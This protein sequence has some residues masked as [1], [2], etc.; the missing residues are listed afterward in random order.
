MKKNIR[1]GEQSL[2]VT[3]GKEADVEA[4]GSLF[5]H[6]DGEFKFHLNNVF[7]SLV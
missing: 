4:I 6:L 2:K 5:L 1:K 3:D 7:I